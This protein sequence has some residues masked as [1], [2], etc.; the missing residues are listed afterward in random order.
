MKLSAK[1]GVD[2]YIR[3][4]LYHVVKNTQNCGQ[5]EKEAFQG[6]RFL[7]DPSSSEIW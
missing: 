2:I 3:S 1:F 7:Y 6:I 4:E 5:T